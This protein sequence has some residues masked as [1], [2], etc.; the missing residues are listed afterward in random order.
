V[1]FLEEL[2]EGGDG[3]QQAGFADL[4]FLNDHLLPQLFLL[5]GLEQGFR[6]YGLV[7]GR[8]GLSCRGHGGS[9]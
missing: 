8:S 9:R 4:G 5:K 3:E 7:V 1:L 2:F 6:G